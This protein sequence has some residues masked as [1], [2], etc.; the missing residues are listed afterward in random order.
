MSYNDLN[1]TSK[2]I[3]QPSG[4]KVKLRDHQLT[5]IAAMLELETESSIIIDKPNITSGLYNIV[6]QKISDIAEFTGS[7]YVI[8]TNTAILADKVGSGKTYMMIGLILSEKI[9]MIHDRFILGTDHYA[10]KMISIKENVNTN[11]IVVPHNLANQWSEFMLKSNLKSLTLNTVSNFNIFFDI[12]EVADYDTNIDG[13]LTIYS[14]IK[15]G[16]GKQT[17]RKTP[18]SKIATKAGGSKTNKVTVV[19]KYERKK[20]NM[21]KVNRILRKYTVIILNVERYRFFK[22]IFKAVKWARVIIDEMDSAKIP[23]QFEEYGNFNWFLTATPT[24]IFNK[25]CRRYVCKIFGSNQHLLPYFTVKNKDEYVDQS[26]VLPQ[27]YVY[28]IITQMQKIVSAIQDLIPHDVLLLINAGNMKEAISKLNC[29]ADTEENIIKVLTD[30]IDVELHNL[31]KELIYVKSV[32][33]IDEN[34]VKRLK[35]DIERCKT[36]LQTVNDRVNSIKDEC[37]FICT[38]SFNN[39]AIL[40]CC[41]NVVCL[42]CLLASFKSSHNKC[43][44]CRHQIKNNSEYHV[45]DSKAKK[46]KNEVTKKGISTGKKFADIDKMVALEETLSYLSKN[47]NCPKILI[48]SDYAQTF[49]KII[50]NI[51]KVS[52]TYAMISG[53]PAHMSNVLEDFETGELNILLLDSQHYGSGLN[54][55]KADYL[56]LFHRMTSELETQVIGRAHRFG[57]KIPLRIIYLINQSENSVSKMSKKPFKPETVD[58]LRLLTNPTK[59][60][61]SDCDEDNSESEPDT[62]VKSA[63]KSVVK[64]KAKVISVSESE[65]DSDSDTKTKSVVKTKSKANSDSIPIAKKMKKNKKKEISSEDIFNSDDSSDTENNSDS[66]SESITIPKKAK[67]TLKK[68]PKK[69]VKKKTLA[70]KTKNKYDGTSSEDILDI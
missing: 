47:V 42:A 22:Q 20:L 6:R 15:R 26:L 9:P 61:Q 70:K 12:E 44:F 54:L 21:T 58:E 28:M 68:A 31:K 24:A 35:E 34:K 66:D 38:E 55:Q 1:E 36:R 65:S 63:T 46:K 23:Q 43:P 51:A 49:D 7:T 52:L 56:I 45:I 3:K 40:E 11:L 60:D 41:K 39:P 53:T 48:F 30:K 4:L 50:K 14:P 13:L 33:P 8:E 64:S 17:A 2:K 67:K 5:S 25:S 19:P 69:V 37:C 29:G 16:R 32:I 59:I 62:K 57:R 18:T 10:I 27:P